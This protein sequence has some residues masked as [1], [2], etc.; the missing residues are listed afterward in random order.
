M[1][2][3]LLNEIHRFQELAGINNEMR[4]GPD[5]SLMSDEEAV[6]KAFE[7]ATNSLGKII[8]ALHKNPSYTRA[9]DALKLW[10]KSVSEKLDISPESVPTD[11]LAFTGRYPAFQAIPMIKQIFVG[12][13]SG[14]EDELAEEDDYDM[15]T[16]SGDTDAM[17]IAEDDFSA[18]MDA[19][20]KD[21]VT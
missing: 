17:N 1:S 3:K 7:G 14:N 8:N 19:V 9:K 12:L 16:P 18:T 13:I 10:I 6:N 5:G 4:V 20:D 2:K 21:P 11:N 15:G